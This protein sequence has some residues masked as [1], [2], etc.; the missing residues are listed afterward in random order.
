MTV[1]NNKDENEHTADEVFQY[2]GNYH[3]DESE[4]VKL[5]IK[6]FA[7]VDFHQVTA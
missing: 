3:W 7:H 2:F 4:R 6:L 1:K 5:K